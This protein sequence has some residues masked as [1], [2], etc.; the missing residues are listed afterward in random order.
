MRHQ[1]RG[2]IRLSSEK[3]K[4]LIVLLA[5]TPGQKH[6]REFVQEMLWPDCEIRSSQ[7]RLRFVLH[8]LRKLIGSELWADRTSLWLDPADV[9]TDVHQFEMLAQEGTVASLATASALY[10]GDLLES[11]NGVTPAFE[12]WLIP[13]RERLRD[14]VREVCWRLFA[15]RTWRGELS[16]AEEVANRYLMIDPYCERMHAGVLRLHVAQGNRARAVGLGGRLRERLA[17]DLQVAPSQEIQALRPLL[18]PSNVPSRHA[19]D[20]GWVLGR[21]QGSALLSKP[22]VA[23]LPFRDVSSG[24]PRFDLASSLTEDVIA[25]L[26]RFRN[27]AVLA[28]DTSFALAHVSSPD[29]RLRELGVRYTVDGRVQRTGNR[30]IV[31]VGLEDKVSSRRIWAERYDGDFDELPAFQERV[32]RALLA[33]IPVEVE[34]SELARVRHTEIHSLSAYEFYLLGR[35]YQRST[36][37]DSHAKGYEYFSRA[38]ERDETLAAAHAYLAL[39]SL[40]GGG[41]QLPDHCAY[42]DRS[43]PHARRATELDPSNPQGHWM[44]GWL[45]QEKHDYELAALHLDL[46]IMVSPG[47]AETLAQTGL[48]CAYAGSPAEGVERTAAAIKLNPH[49]PPAFA[50]IMGKASFAAKRY[51]DALFCLR[52]SPDRVPTNRGWLAAAAAYAARSDE[53]R[54]HARALR[55]LVHGRFSAELLKDGGRPVTWLRKRARF[56]YSADLDHFT[57]GLEMAGL[58]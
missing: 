29:T 25:D 58:E 14:I 1:S 19:F 21:D 35:A 22:L 39:T 47:D 30:L 13:E 5:R 31:T 51:D 27:L 36:A 53:A 10:K 23:V 32:V 34:G 49:Y 40:Q 52:Q 42:V 6:R 8:Q 18:V 15:L 54:L 55:S 17:R 45:L 43:I 24:Q 57:N 50:E 9:E 3:G 20:A 26:S 33:A 46:A 41:A 48:E 38:I 44:M 12:D 11:V 2:P 56:R 37:P 7:G 16:E 4:L 28:R